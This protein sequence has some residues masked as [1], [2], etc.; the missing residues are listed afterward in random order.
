MEYLTNLSTLQSNSQINRQLYHE[1]KDGT[2]NEKYKNGIITVKRNLKPLAVLTPKG[3]LRAKGSLKA[4]LKQINNKRHIAQELTYKLEKDYLNKK[5]LTLPEFLADRKMTLSKFNEN[6]KYTPTTIVTNYKSR[7]TPTRLCV[8]PA[9]KNSV[10]EKDIKNAEKIGYDTTVMLAQFKH[11]K[12]QI[13]MNDTI[14]KYTLQLPNM[15]ETAVSQQVAGITVS[16]DIDDAFKSIKLSDEDALRTVIFTLQNKKGIPTFLAEE[17][18]DQKFHPLIYAYLPYGHVDSPTLFTCAC[19]RTATFYDEH[20]LPSERQVS[21]LWLTEVKNAIQHVYIDDLQINKSPNYLWEFATQHESE[22]MDYYPLVIKTIPSTDTPFTTNQEV[23]K[24]ALVDISPTQHIEITNKAM[25][26]YLTKLIDKLLIVFKFSNL[27][28]KGIWCNDKE[29]EA[30][31]NNNPIIKERA[32]S[33]CKPTTPRPKPELVWSELSKLSKPTDNT[34]L[35]TNE[36]SYQDHLGKRINADGTIGVKGT[37]LYLPTKSGKQSGEKTF[38]PD[39][40]TMIEELKTRPITRRLI[41]SIMAIPYDP[42]NTNLIMAQTVFRHA[43]LMTTLN[44]PAPK[45]DPTETSSKIQ[46]TK[47]WNQIITHPD[48]LNPLFLAIKVFYRIAKRTL[49]K[50]VFPTHPSTKYEIICLGDA[51]GLGAPYDNKGGLY[52]ICIYLRAT[53]TYQGKFESAYAPLFTKTY[54]W[55]KTITTI[56]QAEL[57]AILVGVQMVFKLTKMLD[58]QFKIKIKKEDITLVTDST[59]ALVW[60]RSVDSKY[61]PPVQTLC[62]KLFLWLRDQQLSP[63]RNLYFFNQAKAFF[64]ADM[65]SKLNVKWENPEKFESYYN[66][67]NNL[68]WMYKENW[69]EFLDLNPKFYS[70]KGS[71][72]SLKHLLQVNKTYTVPDSAELNAL[73]GT[74]ETWDA[75]HET[76]T[77]TPESKPDINTNVIFATNTNPTITP[78]QQ[79]YESMMNSKWSKGI[80]KNG[81]ID[82]IARTLLCFW[83]WKRRTISKRRIKPQNNILKVTQIESPKYQDE[84]L[85]EWLLVTIKKHIF[86]E[87]KLISESTITNNTIRPSKN[88]MR[89]TLM[90]ISSH[91]P[92]QKAIKGL[93]IKGYHTFL[94]EKPS[95]DLKVIMCISRTQRSS[96]DRNLESK[97]ALVMFAIES[98]SLYARFIADTSHREAHGRGQIHMENLVMANHTMIRKLTPLLTDITKLC[99]RCNLERARTGKKNYLIYQNSKAPTSRLEDYRQTHD[100][101]HVAVIDVLGPLMAKEYEHRIPTKYWILLTYSPI[102]QRT[103]LT[104]L[105]NLTAESIFLALLKDSASTPRKIFY[106]DAGSNFTPLSNQLTDQ[107]TNENI[108]KSLPQYWQRLLRKNEDLVRNTEPHL[109]FITFAK[110]NHQALGEVERQVGRIKHLC[111]GMRLWKKLIKGDFTFLETQVLLSQLQACL[112]SS[113]LYFRHGVLYTKDFIYKA[114]R[115]IPDDTLDNSS[116]NYYEL[117]QTGKNNFPKPLT[118]QETKSR[119]QVIASAENMKAALSDMYSELAQEKVEQYLRCKKITEGRATT[120]YHSASMIQIGDIVYCPITATKKGRTRRG[121]YRVAWISKYYNECLLVQPRYNPLLKIYRKAKPIPVTRLLKDLYFICKGSQMDYTALTTTDIYDLRELLEEISKPKEIENNYNTI[122]PSGLDIQNQL[123]LT[124]SERREICQQKTLIL[125]KK[126]G[127]PCY[128][129]QRM[130]RSHYRQ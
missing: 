32:K 47:Y 72:G 100:L 127:C 31:L 10:D 68:T 105:P 114:A 39:A 78:N 116:H 107:A 74:P 38:Y 61:N 73:M 18:P 80:K 98:T 7:T 4:L 22:I 12:N 59:C 66:E 43:G 96:R 121:I 29:L 63:F 3:E 53:L 65:I 64:P 126:R 77:T 122:M 54:S 15:V 5:T 111:K 109:N 128:S 48:V 125:P 75:K 119:K 51:G 118:Y 102:V 88:L 16:L 50:F 42:N 49:P 113:P 19:R 87:E 117:F 34:I 115:G 11:Q 95:T 30:K 97:G 55:P 124:D 123:P 90:L 41:A 58:N 76:T 14:H 112:N 103:D 28:V 40:E 83:K 60:S 52:G 130:T 69:N 67:F 27:F 9:Q 33:T 70:T 35:T 106:A 89:Y 108:L 2:T 71:V 46:S 37:E 17:S 8:N 25:S 13:S 82:I 99:S 44:Y 21:D 93:E 56:P 92:D 110:G 94:V 81:I 84:R 6:A 79:W 129:T 57:H 23:L 120:S 45:N 20:I 24:K 85:E 62:A 91:F 101:Y 86:N 26:I 1:D 104:L 36:D